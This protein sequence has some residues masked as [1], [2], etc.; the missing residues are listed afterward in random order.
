[1][2]DISDTNVEKHFVNS[3]Y[4]C[5]AD[6]LF[7]VFPFL[8]SGM[9]RSW[10]GEGFNILKYPDLSIATVILAGM[11]LSKLILAL[12]G[13]SA[14]TRYK[15]RFVFFI[16]LIISFILGPSLILIVTIIDGKNVPQPALFLQP[17]LLISSIVLYSISINTSYFMNKVMMQMNK[18]NEPI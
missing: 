4:A 2:Y 17:V 16:A 7:I 11:S 8:L 10:N 14:L 18:T 15:V 9:L 5:Y 3:M 13:D 12:I 6:I 1:M